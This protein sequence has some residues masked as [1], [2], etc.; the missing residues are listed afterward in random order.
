[1]TKNEWKSKQR[2]LIIKKMCVCYLC[3][4]LVERYRDLSLDH[5]IPRSR[6]GVDEHG[7]WGVSHKDCNWEKGALTYAEYQQWKILENRRNGKKK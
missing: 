5:I 3:G 1:M 6:G 4:K 2:A 7:N